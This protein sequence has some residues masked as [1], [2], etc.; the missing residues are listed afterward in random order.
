[1]YYYGARYYDPKISLFISVD[2]KSEDYPGWMPYHYVHQ[3]PLNLVD[4]TGMAAEPPTDPPGGKKGRGHKIFNFKWFGED[5]SLYQKETFEFVNK[6]NPTLIPLVSDVGEVLDEIVIT[7]KRGTA[8]A[9]AKLKNALQGYSLTAPGKDNKTNS[10][11][12]PV[13]NRTT[14][15]WDVGRIMPFSEAV[16]AE[17]FTPGASL[18]NEDFINKDSYNNRVKADSV[19]TIIGTETGSGFSIERT[20]NRADANKIKALYEKKGLINVGIS[21]KSKKSAK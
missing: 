14:P 19:Y 4:P 5:K 20:T 3:N 11:K 2:Q 21:A 9:P 7:I 18:S 16:G 17:V 10:V 12:P 13:G 6:V 8:D 15:Y 1:M